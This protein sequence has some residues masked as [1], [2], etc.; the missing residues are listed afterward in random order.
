[1]EELIVFNFLSADEKTGPHRNG[2]TSPKPHSSLGAEPWPPLECPLWIWHCRCRWASGGFLTEMFPAPTA[3][4]HSVIHY[5]CVIAP[6]GLLWAFKDLLSPHF[7]SLL[8][9][10]IAESRACRS[11][12]R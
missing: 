5:V 4:L 9:S 3:L 11:D 2:M 6:L 1:M 8:S 10:N 12:A 7:K